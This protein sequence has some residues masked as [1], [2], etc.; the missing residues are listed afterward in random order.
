MISPLTLIQ[1]LKELDIK[2][3]VRQGKLI[4]DAP[5]GALSQILSAQVKAHKQTLKDL[6]EHDPVSD[7]GW[8]MLWRE[9]IQTQLQ[10]RE[11][12]VWADEYMLM[13]T[14]NNGLLKA[15]GQAREKLLKWYMFML[16]RREVTA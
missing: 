15:R 5:K 1:T 11:D 12:W 3:S 16:E 14:A 9:R 6:L 8:V 7:V 13:R 2:L 4:A 10:A